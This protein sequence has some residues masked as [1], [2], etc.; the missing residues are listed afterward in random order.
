M[1]FLGIIIIGDTLQIQDGTHVIFAV[2]T[3]GVFI[4]ETIIKKK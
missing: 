2:A 3:T 1:L 4:I